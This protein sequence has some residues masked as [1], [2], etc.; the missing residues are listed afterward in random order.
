MSLRNQISVLLFLPCLI[1]FLVTLIQL[2]KIRSSMI[3]MVISTSEDFLKQ[4]LISRREA[5]K[6]SKFYFDVHI[7]ALAE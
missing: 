6:G 5:Q 3:D 2:Q 4:E 1:V 7:Q